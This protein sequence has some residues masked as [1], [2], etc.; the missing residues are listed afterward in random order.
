MQPKKIFND[1]DKMP[2]TQWQSVIVAELKSENY[3][4]LF[5]KNQSGITVEPI[6]NQEHIENLKSS[7]FTHYNWDVCDYILVQNATLANQHALEALSNGASGLVFEINT[8]IDFDVLC[9]NILLKH[10]YTYFKVSQNTVEKLIAYLRA[11]NISQNCFIEVDP[12]FQTAPLLVILNHTSITI[13]ATNY[14]QLDGNYTL[15]LAKIIAHLNEYLQYFEDH[16]KINTLKT[17]HI[18]VSVNSDFF[19]EIAKLR[20]LRNLVLFLST[21]YQVS[22]SIHIHAN[23]STL[24]AT[25]D[26][27]KNLIRTSIEAMSAAIGGSNSIN[28]LPFNND[29]KSTN[30]RGHRLARNQ[31]LILKHESYINQ[32][33]DIAA[34]SYYIESITNQLAEQAW[35]QF[36]QIEAKGGILT[37]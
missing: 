23:V 25:E 34:G 20:A 15:E 21:Q 17:I 18:S 22:P 31:Q 33:A 13:N 2:F 27:N 28:V 11:K 24:Q 14:F 5:Y 12:I 37:Q 29:I 32:I 26:L 35:K 10:I 9:N 6:Y 30:T 4:S 8:E 16:Q 19:M 7:T 36:Q 1:F 3:Q